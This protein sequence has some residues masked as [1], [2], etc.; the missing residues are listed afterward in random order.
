MIPREH[1]INERLKFRAAVT[2]WAP[3]LIPAVRCTGNAIT[4]SVYGLLIELPRP[5][6]VGTPVTV[7][8]SGYDIAGEATVRHSTPAGGWFRI[9]LE[10]TASLLTNRPNASS[11]LLAKR[12]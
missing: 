9:G 7:Y 1:R 11:I 10:F 8:V 12:E 5:I 2:V 3:G 6:P 4:Y